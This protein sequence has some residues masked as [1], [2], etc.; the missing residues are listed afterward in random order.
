ML[1]LP[2]LVAHPRVVLAAAA[3]P[4]P[5]ARE[6]F[7]AEFGARAYATVEELASDRDVDAIYIASP[8]QFHAPHTILA[9]RA[10]KHVLVEKPMALTLADCRAMIE[11]AEKAGVALVVGHSHSFDAPIAR[12][13]AIIE[14]GDVGPLRMISA[15]NFT[16]FLYRPRRPEELDSAKGGGVVFNQA[17]HHF[18][19]VRLL[20][21]GLLKCVR[22]ATGAWDP[23]RPTEGAYTCFFTFENGVFGSMTYSGFAHFD[24]DEFLEWIAEGGLPKDASL[25]GAARRMLSEAADEL[26]VKAAHNYGAPG[27]APVPAGV[28]RWHQQF[29]LIVASCERADLRPTAKGVMCYENGARRFAALPPPAI[30][31]AAVIDELLDAVFAGKRPLH[32]GRWGLATMEACFAMLQ[33]AR[34]GREIALQHQIPIGG[35]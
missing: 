19:I 10:R 24:S 6:R 11:A 3:D 34:E 7:A 31:R 13:R 35:R 9:A 26:A 20:G 22:A 25:Y 17:P 30:P 1:M 33:S 23:A 27:V 18:D 8:H 16:D 28:T 12:T 15:M 2:T 32:D 21:G 4:R 5:E 14:S 29:G